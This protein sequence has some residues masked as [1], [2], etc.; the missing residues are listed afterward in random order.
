MGSTNSEV[1]WTI[2]SHCK[3]QCSY[4]LPEDKNGAVEHSIEQYLTVVDK[5]QRAHY[6]HHAQIHWTIGG[7]EPLHYPHLNLLLKKIKSRPAKVTVVTSGDDSWFSIYGILN[8]ID[9]LVLTYHPWQ[10]YDVF[11]FILEQCQEKNISVQILVPLAPG[12]IHESRLVVERYLSL[13]YQ[14]QEQVLQD[15]DR[16]PHQEYSRIDINRINYQ[17][18]DYEPEPVD[19]NAPNPYHV[20]LSVVNDQDPVYTGRPCYAGV[21]WMSISARGFASYS[22]C[23]G[24]NEHYNVFD[25]A[26]QPPTSH[27]PCSVNQCRS[28]QDRKKIRILA[29]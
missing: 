22:Q 18:D 4:C 8:Y 24:R 10:N 28:S 19:P 9:S 29:S 20:S 5:I 3:F 1:T 14:C 25:P 27:F 15:I 13:G 6:Q 17:A 12:K 23:G 26:W 7:G 11:D 16:Q 21:D 2:N